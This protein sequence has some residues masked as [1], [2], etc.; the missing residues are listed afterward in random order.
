MRNILLIV[1][2][3]FGFS[4]V[5]ADVQGSR[6]H[7]DHHH[8]QRTSVTGATGPSGA[9]GATGT[10]ATGATGPT[11]PTGPTGATGSLSP[12]FGNFFTNNAPGSNLFVAATPVIFDTPRF[13]PQ[14][15]TQT[16][17]PFGTVFQLVNPGYYSISWVI[18]VGSDMAPIVVMLR[19][20]QNGLPI[21]PNPVN[22]TLIPIAGQDILSGEAII[23]TQFPLENISFT[24]EADVPT[25]GYRNPMLS[26]TQI[27]EP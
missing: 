8:K 16:G 20:L 7:E 9:T 5:S 6:C 12:S 25:G 21:L 24:I 14:G 2:T 27:S 18:N 22:Q 11:G 10:G 4:S 15:V 3:V 1:G 17:A 19:L 23:Q 13:I 26:I